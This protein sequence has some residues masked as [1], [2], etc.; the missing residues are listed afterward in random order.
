[1]LEFQKNAAIEILVAL[2]SLFSNTLSSEYFKA[3]VALKQVD[4]SQ[5][6]ML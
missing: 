6:C 2:S 1:M 4:L 5:F 3:K